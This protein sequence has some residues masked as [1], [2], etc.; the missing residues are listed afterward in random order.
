M[1]FQ[2][3][4]SKTDGVSSLKIPFRYLMFVVTVSLM[5]CNNAIV[6]HDFARIS[7]AHISYGG[8]FANFSDYSNQPCVT[9]S[10]AF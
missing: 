4:N 1:T 2:C 9:E 6:D 10:N 8:T 7:I 3:S 5:Q